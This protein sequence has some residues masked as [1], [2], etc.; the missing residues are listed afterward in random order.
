MS[1]M[2]STLARL[3]IVE[4]ITENAD[5]ATL[6]FQGGG[7]GRLSSGETGYPKNLRLARRSHA[8]QYPVGVRFGEGDV[9]AALVRA[10]NDVPTKISGENA[11]C[12]QV[13]FEGHDG[14]FQ[15][16]R[17]HS[18]FDRMRSLLSD[19]T[20]RRTRVWFIA[21]KSELALLDLR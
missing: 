15:L 6:A 9:V 10:D 13:F 16:R 11:D 20:Q 21:E 5:G 12:V 2:L 4:A 19:A 17:E 3:M 14:I 1:E 18:D 8:S 7:Q